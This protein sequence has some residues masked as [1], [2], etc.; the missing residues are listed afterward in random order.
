MSTDSLYRKKKKES[1]ILLKYYLG[2][3]DAGA[4]RTAVGCPN[5]TSWGAV[6]YPRFLAS[7]LKVVPNA[8]AMIPAAAVRIRAGFM[9][10]GIMK[11]Q[12]QLG[13]LND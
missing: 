13:D 8:F 3:L 6:R 2:N 4:G 10:T 9:I 5:R 7:D 12:Q 1:N 11:N